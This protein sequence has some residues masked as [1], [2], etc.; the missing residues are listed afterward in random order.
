[1]ERATSP[2]TTSRPTIFQCGTSRRIRTASIQRTAWRSGLLIWR[3]LISLTLFDDPSA[4]V[5]S[6]QNLRS[7]GVPHV[8]A[9]RLHEPM[10]RAGSFIVHTLRAAQ[11]GL[12]WRDLNREAGPLGR[13]LHQVMHSSGCL[14]ATRNCPRGTSWGNGPCWPALVHR[15]THQRRRSPVM[16]R[17]CAGTI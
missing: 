14:R 1:M 4:T 7:G 16:A 3:V 2:L 12:R 13:D 10:T 11:A 15:R 5:P 8:S 6:R 9:A 17:T